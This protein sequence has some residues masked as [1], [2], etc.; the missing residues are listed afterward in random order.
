[1]ILWFVKK[2]VLRLLISYRIILIENIFLD[3]VADTKKNVDLEKEQERRHR[4]RTYYMMCVL[5]VGCRVIF[6]EIYFLL[7]MTWKISS[8]KKVIFHDVVFRKK[9][10]DMRHFSFLSQ[11]TRV[12]HYQLVVNKT[13]S[14]GLINW[15][16]TLLCVIIFDWGKEYESIWLI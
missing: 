14:N 7:Q 9:V 4:V 10:F 8:F 5:C 2:V 15:L 11:L 3:T 6:L 16:I 1:M 13:E 12:L